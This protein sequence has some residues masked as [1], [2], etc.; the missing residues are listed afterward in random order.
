MKIL[1]LSDSVDDRVYSEHIHQTYRDVD[2]VLG[3]GDLPIYYLEFVADALNKPVLYV[4]GNHDTEAEL[5]SDGQRRVIPRGCDPIDG[6]VVRYGDLVF[7]G[8]GGSNRYRRGAAQQFSESQMRRRIF[9]LLP[10]LLLTR[11]RRGR[12]VDVVVAHSPP[13]GIHD[14]SDPA[15]AGFKTFLMLMTRIKPRYLLHGH[16]DAWL[17]AG[18]RET[19][20]QETRVVNVNPVFRL[21]IPPTRDGYE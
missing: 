11:A 8:L 4:R 7:L 1:A 2:L 12:F 13:R 3:C 20:F 9:R 5:T 16:V 6:R 17:V 14:M 10:R 19:H 15:H 18:G 21:D